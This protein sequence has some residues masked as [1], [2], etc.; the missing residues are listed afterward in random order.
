M[1][2]TDLAAVASVI[3]SIAVAVSLIYLALQVRQAEKNQRALMQQGRADRVSDLVLR[4]SEPNLAGVFN[5]GMVDPGA[6]SADEINRFVTISRA[7]LVSAEDSFL[8]RRAGMLGDEAFR[9][10]AAGLRNLFATSPGLRVAWRLTSQQY[11]PDFGAFMEA[12]L[13][14]MH[15][16]AAPE[17]VTQWMRLVELDKSQHA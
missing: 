10:F 17:R 11:G 15:A 2:L 9:S 14:D 3:S 6:L 1:T 4:I 7:M 5:K 12:Q 16:Q 8:Q 13:S